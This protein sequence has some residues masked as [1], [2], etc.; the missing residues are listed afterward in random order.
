MNGTSAQ[1]ST[2]ERSET[3]VH[4]QLAVDTLTATNSHQH[5]WDSTLAAE[6]ATRPSYVL[7]QVPTPRNIADSADSPACLRLPAR[8]SCHTQGCEKSSSA[9]TAGCRCH[10]GINQHL[11]VIVTSKLP[12]TP[13]GCMLAIRT[14]NAPFLGS[15]N[16][17]RTCPFPKK[18]GGKEKFFFE[19]QIPVPP[20]L[21]HA[22]TQVH[23]LSQPK[24][25]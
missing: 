8:H 4:N 2:Q 19:W 14:S 22:C 3:A 11:Q 5:Y 25:A 21:A 10:E 9:A 1:Q 17:F 12:P 6:L 23:R 13:L 15:Q 16:T 7:Q 24:L 18:N 20:S